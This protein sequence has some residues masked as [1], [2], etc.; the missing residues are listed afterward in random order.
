LLN[1]VLGLNGKNPKGGF[2]LHE[3]KRQHKLI[4]LVLNLHL[5]AGENLTQIM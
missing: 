3:N 2:N 1:T 4:T 5:V